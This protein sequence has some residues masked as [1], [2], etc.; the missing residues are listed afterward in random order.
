MAAVQKQ[1][2][3]VIVQHY[4]SLHSLLSDP[5]LVSKLIIR[6]HHNDLITYSDQCLLDDC[7]GRG[8]AHQAT[9][10][11]KIVMNLVLLDEGNFEKFVK[12]LKED[13][14]LCPIA[15]HLLKSYRESQC[16]TQIASIQDDENDVHIRKI[17]NLNM[18]HFEALHINV[19]NTSSTNNNSK[20]CNVE[21][22]WV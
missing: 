18:Q 10:L 20:Y 5:G 1:A 6:L 2:R 21:M 19:T 8:A 11:L 14:V 12:V 4:D 7:A 9:E 17:H 15:V 16:G 22:M 13:P 3:D